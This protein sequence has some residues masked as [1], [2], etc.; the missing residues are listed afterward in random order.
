MTAFL[1]DLFLVAAAAGAGLYCLVLSRRIAR[2]SDTE[3]GLGA[4]LA[5]LS[6]QTD[7]LAGTIRGA[8]AQGEDTLARLAALDR[9]SDRAERLAQRIELLMTAADR[10]PAAAAPPARA[11]A[12]EPAPDRDSAPDSAPGSALGT[13]AAGPVFRRSEVAA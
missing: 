9:A 10:E 5:A 11:A 3:S 8:K 6:E 1:S 2:L 7:A 13:S 4:T 12:P